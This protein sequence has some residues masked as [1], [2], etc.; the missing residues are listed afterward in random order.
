MGGIHRNIYGSRR[1]EYREYIYGSEEG[2]IGNIYVVPE[3]G[4]PAAGGEALRINP[5]NTNLPK[6]YS[7]VEFR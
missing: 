6:N 3:E 2:N 1:R 4:G 5:A 7:K